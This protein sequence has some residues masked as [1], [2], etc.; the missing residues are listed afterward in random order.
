MVKT[1]GV[2]RIAPDRELDRR[3]AA[4]AL[5]ALG[6]IAAEPA[7]SLADTAIVGH[8]GRVQ[9]DS[10]AIAAT[11]LT[12]TAWV[13]I[14][15]TT[16]T[17]SAVAGL[18]AGRATDRAA[19]SAGAAYLVAAAGGTA[20]A[21][22]MV[23]AA[24]WVAA[25]LG[26]HG[27]VLSGSV[28]YLRASAAGLPF[29]YL[30]YAGNGHLI[31]L[32]DTRTP[33]RIAV[34]ANVLNVALE[35]LLVYGVHLGLLGS[36]WGTVT[37][38]VAAAALY[39]GASWRRARVR[40]RRPGRAE[41]A[42]LL[43]DGHQLSV[44]TI[45]LGVVP[46]TTTAIA[47]RLGPVA[48]G[49]Q[50]VAMRVWYLL[51]LLLD[52]LAV[53]AQVYVSSCLGAGDHAGAHLVGR[54]TM[55]LGLIAGIGLGVVTAGLAF[56]V[57]ALFTSDLAVRHA[58]TVALEVAAL[59]QPMAALA[60]VLDG[61]ILG[62][63]DYV[64]MRRAMILAILAYVPVAAL[65]LRFPGWACPGSGSPWD[66][67]SRPAPRSSAGAGGPRP[68]RLRCWR[69]GR[70]VGPGWRARRRAQ[71]NKA[72][73]MYEMKGALSGRAAPDP[74]VAWLPRRR[75]PPAGARRPREP[76]VSQLFPCPGVAPGWCPFPTVNVCLHAF[77]M[78]AQESAG[79]H[80][81]FF[82]CPHVVH[83]MPPV[84]RTSQWLSTGF[85][86]SCP[87]IIHRLPGVTRRIPILAFPEIR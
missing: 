87:Q 11:A 29:L 9:L 34:T 75:A 51:A 65:V 52:A 4:L 27:L 40:P 12:M 43:R 6:S 70:R 5:P 30:S 72:P 54:R 37:A 68:S 61:L 21:V 47:A 64:A 59:T 45:A 18:A 7:Y 84:I 73:F 20:V 33:L 53:P 23:V 46:L 31:G 2:R 14:F 57:P 38:Q 76:P 69:F 41:V 85:C 66:S 58:A 1:I 15:L 62:L 74:P 10:L 49:G 36:A 8:L 17:T 82:P 35:L 16:A 22:A 83:R 44:R 80:F 3:I 60:F 48:L 26:A 13:A 39:A 81:E 42:A 56:W 67:G 55:R 25:L 71:Y 86:T 24:P 19:R 77:A 78:V 50:Q 79:I 32:A 28:G 63:S